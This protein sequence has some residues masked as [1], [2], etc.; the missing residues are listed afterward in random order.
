MIKHIPFLLACSCFFFSSMAIAVGVNV[1]EN[2]IT[3]SLTSEPPNLDSSLSQDTT[4]GFVLGLV[5]EGLVNMNRHSQAEAGVA[6]RWEVNG[7]EAT[8]WLRKDARWSNGERI[9]AHD[10]VYAWR[11]LVDP[12]TAASGSAFFAYILEYAEEIMAGTRPVTDLGVSA[13][14]DWTLRVKLSRPAPYVLQVF[15]GTG[16]MPL[17]RQF[18]EA[19]GDRYGA[20]AQHIL[21]NGPFKM[22]SWIHNSKIEMSR[23]P[24]YWGRQEIPLA[25]I[26]IGYITSDTRSLLNLYKNKELAEL[27]LDENVLNDAANSGQRIRKAP[28]NCLAW[29]IMN[30]SADRP[31]QNKTLREAV[32]LA[33]D[34]DTYVNNIVGLPGTVKIDSPFTQRIRGINTTFQKEYPAAEITY[35]INAARQKLEAAKRE[36]GVTDIPPLILLANETR[37][38]EAEYIQSQLKSA[39]GLTI[40][41]DKQTFKQ[42]IAKMQRSDFDMARAGFCGGSITDPVF[43]AGIFQ[44]DSSFNRGG[45]NNAE[46]DQLL[47]TTHYTEDPQ[48]RMDA[49]GKMQQLIFDEIPVIPTHQSAWVYIQD[50]RVKSLRRFPVVNYSKGY[51]AP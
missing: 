7:K 4:S 29:V 10:F 44:S 41:I 48:Q 12:L 50:Q 21:Y 8:F 1:S 14:D 51:I 43:F 19:Q 39:L 5:N 31:L 28:T 27:R 37:Q 2:Q 46:Y 11:R 36:M 38:I 49:F 9:T 18:V 6:E 13:V 35:D 32:R 24:H 25:G 34:R 20:E 33:F 45:F 15:S 23:N 17:N 22:D 40:R 30:M 47:H 26:Q 42:A 3:L 16:Y